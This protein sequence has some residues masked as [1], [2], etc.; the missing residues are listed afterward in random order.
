MLLCLYL[1]PCILI[2]SGCASVPGQK[3]DALAW[4]DGEPITK[5]DLGYSLQIAHRRED[6]SITKKFDISEYLQKLIDDRLIVQEGRRMNLED[7]PLIREKVREFVLRESVVKL[8][9]EEITDKVSVSEEDVTDYYRQNYDVLTL[10]VIETADE[11]EAEEILSEIRDGRGFEEFAVEYASRSG[12]N[13]RELVV[14]RKSLKPVIRDAVSGLNPGD[15]SGV[16]NTQDNYSI[17]KV[18]SIQAAPDEELESVRAEIE[19]ALREQKIKKRSDEYLA[20][21]RNKYEV[22]IDRELMASIDDGSHKELLNDSRPVAEIK[23]MALTAGE[24]ATMLLTRPGKPKEVILNSW[25][26]FKVVDLE[27]LSRNYDVNTDLKDKVQRYKNVLLKGAFIREV[28]N[29]AIQITEKDAEDYYMAHQENYA[30]P[31]MYRIQ[32]ITL[33]SREEAQD[34][35]NSLEGG[36]NFS[37]LAKT[38]SRDSFAE[39]GGVMEWKTKA[40]LPEPVRE[41]IDDLKQGDIGPILNIDQEF[42][43]FRLMEKSA[44]EIEPF[45]AVRTVVYN[46]AYKKKFQGIYDSYIDKLR[47]DARIEL[48]DGAVRAFEETFKK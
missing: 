7:S 33:N 20:E 45:N 31:T 24:F 22:K 47:K 18:L 34:M 23:G 4:V 19:K 17:L 39:G 9:I 8:Y 10:N 43:V 3:D 21:L 48:N 36:A 44:R 26:D 25:I 38:K 35:L 6:L 12:M 14:K 1:F 13:P 32:Q 46:A 27:A 5:D 2:A 41:I 30:K 16:I 15:I 29:P 11:K 28:I 42:L 40:Q 37:W